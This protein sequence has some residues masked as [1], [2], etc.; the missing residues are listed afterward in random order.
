LPGFAFGNRD[1][2]ARQLSITIKSMG[3]IGRRSNEGLAARN[4]LAQNQFIK[5][6]W[7]KVANAASIAPI[8]K[9]VGKGPQGEET[10]A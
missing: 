10:D 5:G 6:Q 1:A 4:P 3:V 7:L 2:P 9:A 8:A